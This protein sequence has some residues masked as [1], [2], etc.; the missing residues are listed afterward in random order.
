[1]EA[2]DLL[3]LGSVPDCLLTDGLRRRRWEQAL[4]SDLH[5]FSVTCPECRTE[6]QILAEGIPAG[7]PVTC[8]RCGFDLGVWDELADGIVVPSAPSSPTEQDA[9]SWAA[10]GEDDAAPSIE[11]MAVESFRS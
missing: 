10:A 2:A 8:S 3:D 11:L 5:T 6:V 7:T 4:R 9:H 1:M